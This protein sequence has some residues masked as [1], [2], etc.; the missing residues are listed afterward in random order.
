LIPAG[1]WNFLWVIDF[2]LFELDPREQR[3]YARHHPFTSPRADD[4]DRIESDPA[5]VMARAYDVVLNG[6]E[7]GGGSI[8]IHDPQLQRRMFHALG[9]REEEAQRR[10]GFLL[11]AFRYGAPPHGGI[12]L[13]LDRIIMLMAGAAS[14]RDVMGFP[15]TTSGQ[16]LM[17]GAPSR[18]EPDQ[19]RDLSVRI[20]LPPE[21]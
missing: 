7:L 1:L 18:V 11:D 16:D 8:R 10:F 2:P 9:I 3:W 17:T 19:L 6:L 14:I 4:V 5:G 15:K 20:D 21:K 13:G 12:A